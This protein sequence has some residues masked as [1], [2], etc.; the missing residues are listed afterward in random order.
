MHKFVIFLSLK[1]W[2][3]VVF[4]YW[5]NIDDIYGQIGPN[6]SLFRFPEF[7][8]WKMGKKGYRNFYKI[9]AKLKKLHFFA[10]CRCI[11]HFFTLLIKNEYGNIFFIF[12][13]FLDWKIP[14]ESQKST[15]FGNF[16]KMTQKTL[17]SNT[18]VTKII[19]ECNFFSAGSI[20]MIF[21][22]KKA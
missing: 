18:F 17:N 20:W 12:T 10:K 11:V 21:M 9:Y 4:F 2:F 8:F 13:P 5:V 1:F 19:N 7:V 16:E 3:L 14:T 15:I 22:G 6:T